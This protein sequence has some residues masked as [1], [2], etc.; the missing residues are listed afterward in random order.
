MTKI[1]FGILAGL[2]LGAAVTWKALQHGEHAEGK[3]AEKHQEESHVIHTNDQI[4]VRLDAEAQKKA[5]LQLSPLGDASLAPEIKATA[6]VLD[7]AP[8]AALLSENAAARAALDASQKE[9][10]R[11]K[12]LDRDQNTSARALEAATAAVQRDQIAAEAARL[13]FVTSWGPAIAGQKDLT[14]F[15]ASL[16]SQE[17][18]L[19]RVDLTPGDTPKTPPAGIRVASLNAPEL[20]EDTQLLGP[21]AS[22]DPQTQGHG[23]LCLVK[24]GALIPGATLSA[25]LTLAGA[26]V[27]GVI[28]PRAAIVR[29][30][31]EAFVYVQTDPDLFLRKEIELVRPVAQGWF[32]EEGLKAGDKVVTVGAQQLLSEE[33]KGEGGEE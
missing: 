3:E 20:P 22:I 17:S 16:A 14:G 1:I 15:V 27:H 25:R 12:V 26:P 23:Y 33:L 19:V 10:E 13:K 30:E 11:L 8:L 31:G 4:F 5:G 18:A 21:A 28:V 2:I 32:V 6:R 9:L 7:P 24:G 29:H